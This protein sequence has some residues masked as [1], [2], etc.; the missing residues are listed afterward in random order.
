[1]DGQRTRRDLVRDAVRSVLR[2][3]RDT[4]TALLGP[5]NQAYGTTVTDLL[6][7]ALA[8]ALDRL[9]EPGPLLALLEGHGRDA[10]LS[11]LDVTRTVGW[12]TR[13]Y[14]VRLDVSSVADTGGRIKTVKETL[15]AVPTRGAGFGPLAYLGAGD[16]LLR[17]LRPQIGFNYLGNTNLDIGQG[18]ATGRW[19]FLDESIGPP[20]ASSESRPCPLELAVLCDGDDLVLTL[21]WNRRHFDQATIDRLLGSMRR[22]LTAIADYCLARPDRERTLSDMSHTSL[23]QD[24]FDALFDD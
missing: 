20:V 9:R 1:M 2:L 21:G 14:P 15:R 16:D 3:S 6:L 8:T 4:S 23:S 13:L 22:E 7:T 5:A 19:S 11:T 10:E 12:F 17:A 18:E 24:D